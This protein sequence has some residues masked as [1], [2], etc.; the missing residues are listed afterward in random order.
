V[1]SKF[2]YTLYI[3]SFGL[4]VE[5]V[6]KG[7]LKVCGK[8]RVREK[9]GNTMLLLI[10]A[11]CLLGSALSLF[12]VWGLFLFSMLFFVNKESILI[13]LIKLYFLKEEIWNNGTHY[14][15]SEIGLLTMWIYTA[16]PSNR[17][18]SQAFWTAERLFSGLLL[19]SCALS[20]DCSGSF[21]NNLVTI[22]MKVLI[23]VKMLRIIRK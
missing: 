11:V 1:E 7:V 8:M 5:Y 19:A 10:S 2:F 20:I 9:W 22:Y 21:V 12:N 13:V 3:V 17:L 18:P 6:I 15:L 14:G 23:V 4:L 16:L